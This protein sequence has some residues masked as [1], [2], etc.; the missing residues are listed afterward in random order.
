[1]PRVPRLNLLPW[2][3]LIAGALTLSACGG[4]TTAS[5]TSQA[6]TS[7]RSA[8][9]APASPQALARQLN[10]R[11]ADLPAG[12]RA[13]GAAS[14]GEQG[15]PFA[16]DGCAAPHA[17]ALAIA[18]SARYADAGTGE[19]VASGVLVTGEA[20]DAETQ[21][22]ASI[23]AHAEACLREHPAGGLQDVAVAKLASPVHG[24]PI[25]GLRAS[26]CAAGAAGCSAA[27]PD[28]IQDHVFFALGRSVLALELSAP[29]AAFPKT[30]ERRLVEALYQRA[31]SAQ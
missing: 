29:A 6:T 19:T 3:S 31:S 23:G 28:E 22:F 13:Q 26:G 11:A 30:L 4:A 14:E 18:S 10:L 20:S 1:M 24:L 7:A 25:Y 2:V 21:L 8:E 16:S 17:E 27:D 15:G 9:A 12:F 5:S